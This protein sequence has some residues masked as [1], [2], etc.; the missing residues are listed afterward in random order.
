MP[1]CILKDK[2]NLLNVHENSQ[3]RLRLSMIMKNGSGEA[4]ISCVM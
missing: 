3:A 1:C 2:W 4:D